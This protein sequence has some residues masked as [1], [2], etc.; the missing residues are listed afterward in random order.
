MTW[1][2]VQ[3]LNAKDLLR[4]LQN[5]VEFCRVLGLDSSVELC[6]FG[7]YQERLSRLITLLQPD[8]IGMIQSGLPQEVITDYVD[9]SI[10]L[11]ECAEFCFAIPYLMTL[12]RD[13]AAQ[14]LKVILGGQKVLTD[15]TAISNQSRNVLFEIHLGAQAWRAGIATQVSPVA[16]LICE[17]EGRQLFIECKR[18][19]SAK[20][21]RQRIREAD[22]QLQRHLHL[23][24]PT[25]RGV[26]AISLSKLLNPDAL[27]F[28]MRDRVE[29]QRIFEEKVQ[30]LAEEHSDVWSRLSKKV[31]GILFT[32][33]MA[34]LEP[35]ST[36]FLTVHHSLGYVLANE[37]SP[38]NRLFEMFHNKLSSVTP[39]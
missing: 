18:P 2:R 31:I 23:A 6:R 5:A 19:L 21:I 27:L 38:S 14:K 24:L 26:I 15:E 25:C 33:T 34:G 37:R 35:G 28:A 4:S 9:D 12:D 7:R 30:A 36:L 22:K 17:F 1:E 20:K 3:P 16:D 32:A 10:I 29:G 11:I 39:F 13:I 8:E